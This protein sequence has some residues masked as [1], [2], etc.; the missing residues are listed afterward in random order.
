MI[1]AGLYQAGNVTSIGCK[2]NIAGPA[3]V[4]DR[5][6]SEAVTDFDHVFVRTG[7]SIR[8]NARMNPGLVLM[9]TGTLVGDIVC[10]GLSDLQAIEIRLRFINLRP[11]E[12]VI[13]IRLQCVPDL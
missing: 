6:I 13:S 11:L 5:F 1:D 4:E 9:G 2:G 3:A 7:T 12:D 10:C 8:Q